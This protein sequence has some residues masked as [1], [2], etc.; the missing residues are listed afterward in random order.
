MGLYRRGRRWW[1]EI[2]RNG[3]RH[4][5]RLGTSDYEVAI[6]KAA[7]FIRQVELGQG[8]EVEAGM[9]KPILELVDDFERELCRR[10][11]SDIYVW[12][13]CRRIRE[14]VRGIAK[15]PLLAQW[16]TEAIRD[17]LGKIENASQQNRT[18]DACSAFSRYL[19][20]VRHLLQWN[21]V[22]TIDVVDEDE[23]I[24]RRPFQPDQF[25]T[26]LDSLLRRRRLY[27]M[28]AYVTAV[29]TGFRRGE[30]RAITMKEID[31]EKG[32]IVVPGVKT[33]NGDV[34]H[35]HLPKVTL[36]LL[37]QMRSLYEKRCRR[38]S[39]N[40]VPSQLLFFDNVPHAA[41]LRGD[42][43][44]AGIPGETAEGKIDFHSLRVTFTTFMA[45]AG[46]HPSLAQ[47]LARH[48]EIG[49]TLELYT[50]WCDLEGIAAIDAGADLWAKLWT[51]PDPKAWQPR[52]TS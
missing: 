29:T 30:L 12:D 27:R 37:R 23:T 33:K 14:V 13:R 32:L 50:K 24:G 41:T 39:V 8:F 18:R 52:A 6:L 36:E 22:E 46:V 47:R 1:I 35:M 42:C 16:T 3:I 25:V 26:V 49:L 31:L 2:R 43:E 40:K 48:S 5:K 28:A 34:V 19:V 20:R 10:R 45:K 15:E 21:P 4:R 11:R 17:E 7:R 44:I 51:P 38:K 9:T